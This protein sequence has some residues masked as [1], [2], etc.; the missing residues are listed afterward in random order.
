M[1]LLKDKSEVKNVFQSF[2]TMVKTQFG[3]K[4]EVFR[5]DNGGEFFSDQLGIF[6]TKHGIVH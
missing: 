2:Y 6:L 4:I 1:F 5:T 3:V